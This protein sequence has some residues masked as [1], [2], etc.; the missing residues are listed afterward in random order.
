MGFFDSL[1]ARKALRAK[2]C[3]GFTAAGPW[4]LIGGHNP[5][6]LKWKLITEAMQNVPKGVQPGSRPGQPSWT[7]AKL[8]HFQ[9]SAQLL[10]LAGRLDRIRHDGS[11]SGWAGASQLEVLAHGSYPQW[12][13]RWRRRSCWSLRRCHFSPTA[14]HKRY[15][16]KQTARPAVP[17]VR[18]SAN[19]T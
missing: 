13:R 2:L 15:T 5:L 9:Q 16:T 3:S 17:L 6:P 8:R 18:I 19:N 14:I 1:L 10:N 4:P 11:G 7:L 12:P